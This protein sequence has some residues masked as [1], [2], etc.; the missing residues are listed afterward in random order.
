MKHKDDKELKELTKDLRAEFG[1]YISKKDLAN[2]FGFK[3]TRSIN[4][5]THELDMFDDDR[6]GLHPRYT[7]ESVARYMLNHTLRGVVC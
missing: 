2:I 1:W 3:D 4:G 7:T 5:I 6:N